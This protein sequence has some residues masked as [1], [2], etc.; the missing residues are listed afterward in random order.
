[1][2]QRF[3]K[4]IMPSLLQ[5]KLSFLESD[6]KEDM[7]SSIILDTH[8]DKSTNVKL[9]DNVLSDIELLRTYDGDTKETIY[10]KLNY[11]RFRGSEKY[12]ID[13]LCNPKHDI[14]VLIERQ[15]FLKRLEPLVK[16][17]EGLFTDAG[18]L[19][20]DMMWI[21][22]STTEEI[23][24]LYDLIY[25]KMLFLNNLNKRGIVLTGV[26]IYKI[27]F[28]PLIGIVSPIAYFILPY[29]I[30]T[31]KFNAFR[32]GFTSYMKMMFNV[33]FKSNI[34]SLVLGQKFYSVRFIS[35]AFSLL[36]WFQ[37][38]FNSVD[39]S[40]ASYK[41]CKFI[42][43]KMRNVVSFIKIAKYINDIFWD[44]AISKYFYRD[45]DI[46]LI[47]GTSYF[48]EVI[49]KEFNLISNF[50][51]QLAIYKIFKKDNYIPLIKRCFM[52]DAIAS[53]IHAKIKMNLSYTGYVKNDIP[54]IKFMDL[55]HP[56]I[57]PKKAVGN[58]VII[59][60]E[61]EPRNVILTG[62]NAGGKSTLIKAVIV[63]TIMA[64]TICVVNASHSEMTPFHYISSQIHVPDCKGKESLFEA[65]M[66]RSRDVLETLKTVE[67]KHSIVFMD[68][69][70]NS[71]NPIEGIAGAY[72]ILKTMA[73]YHHNLSIVST[74]F[75]YLTKLAKQ[76]NTCFKALKMN[77]RKKEGL[78]GFEFPYKLVQGVSKQYIALELLK[79]NGFDENIL[80]DAMKIKNELLDL[81]HRSK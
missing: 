56:S 42:T 37:S 3:K 39:V 71:T 24:S 74:H 43:N 32:V 1:M 79:L 13:L 60:T 61:K 20:D 67:N 23:E 29:I 36:F 45:K 6:C 5:E 64:Q 28:S 4:V 12:F 65:E 73:Q 41:I 68:E 59:G 66:Y 34:T 40:K 63:S 72:A 52:I 15:G 53:V 11:C 14:N 17:H 49:P 7:Y 26:N 80:E 35:Y 31:I 16:E 33:M 27:L 25:F 77:V 69:I 54:S 2:L 10:N 76:Y 57:D 51:K 47:D 8:I 21:Y 44:D 30:M 78:D 46:Q 22:S 81:G 19:E 18:R 55:K 50:G 48:D 38:I 70:F 62:P 75:I 58:N 9:G